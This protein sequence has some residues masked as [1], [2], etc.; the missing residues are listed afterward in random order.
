MGVLDES[1]F[2]ARVCACPACGAAKL[3][4]RAYLDRRVE[5]MLADPDDDGRWAHD[6]EKFIDGVYRITCAA[7]GHVALDAPDCPRCHAPGALAAALASPS[8]LAVPKRCPTCRAT[9]LVVLAFAPASVVYQHGTR[10]PPPRPLAELGEPGFHVAAIVC[11]ACGP[12]AEAAGCPICA[13]PGPL[14]E[15]P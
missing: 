2:D 9:E 14:R 7:C 15:R 6:G 13:A 5:V 4:L 1:T 11:D 12:I 3:E 10:P 8:R